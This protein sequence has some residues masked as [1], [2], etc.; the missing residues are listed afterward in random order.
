MTNQDLQEL[1]KTYHELGKAFGETGQFDQKMVE[2]L[3][4]PEKIPALMRLIVQLVWKINGN[5]YWD[6]WLKENKA[7]ERSFARPYTE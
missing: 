5:G 3:A 6:D 4:K 1:K 2:E 7:S